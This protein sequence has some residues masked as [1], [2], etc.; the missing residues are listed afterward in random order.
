MHSVRRRG[1]YLLMQLSEGLLMLHL[2]MSGSLRFVAPHE[3]PL[4]PAGAHDHFDLHT[5]KGQL[6][7]HDPRR[8]GAVMYVPAEND[9]W[10]RRLLDHLGMEPLDDSF[11]F[12]TFKAGLKASRTPIKQLLLSG[13]VVVGVGNIYASEV[14]FMARIAPTQPACEVGPRKVR[15][16]F[17]EIR[18]VLELAV[19]QGERRCVISRR[20]TAWQATSS[21]RPRCMAARASPARIAARPYSCCARASA[22][23][24]LRA[25]SE[26]VRWPQKE[27]R[28]LNVS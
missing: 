14:L 25:V 18:R 22:A 24:T 27:E 5:S 23:P 4:G 16:L 11:L 3:L 21:C 8:F 19:E 13:S 20:P 9:P 1:K 28:I 2:G 26:S 12:E 15:R 6:R 17:E 10:A 7:L